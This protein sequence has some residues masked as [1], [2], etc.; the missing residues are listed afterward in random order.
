VFGAW[1]LCLG[2][3]LDSIEYWLTLF[4]VAVR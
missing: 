4:D 2:F 3:L 1:L